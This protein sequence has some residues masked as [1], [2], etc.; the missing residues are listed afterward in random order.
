MALRS[1]VDAI[2]VSSVA[3]YVTR[4]CPVAYRM[5]FAYTLQSNEF[6]YE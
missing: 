6:E 3:K 1:L 5:L 2:M 4:L